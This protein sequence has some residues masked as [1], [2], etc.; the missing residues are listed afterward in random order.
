MRPVNISIFAVVAAVGNGVGLGEAR[1][2]HVMIQQLDR[3]FILK[4]GIAE[5]FQKPYAVS[6]LIALCRRYLKSSAASAKTF[7]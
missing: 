3:D 1:F 5:I 4:G 6:G 2:I 7:H